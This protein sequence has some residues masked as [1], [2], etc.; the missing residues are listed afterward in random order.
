VGKTLGMRAPRLA[1]TV[2]LALASLSWSG[3]RQARK[4]M[5]SEGGSDPSEDVAKLFAVTE[6]WHGSARPHRMGVPA[7]IAA[8][9]TS[10]P[11]AWL[12]NPARRTSI[13]LA[14]CK[15]LRTSSPPR[16]FSPQPHAMQHPPVCRGAA[17]ERAQ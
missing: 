17:C 9:L 5:E 10:S 15:L 7:L 2:E 12:R 6:T 3:A 4:A 13:T 8:A 14:S 16:E 11:G 1:T